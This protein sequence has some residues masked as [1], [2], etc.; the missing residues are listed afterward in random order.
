[1]NVQENYNFYNKQREENNHKRYIPYTIDSTM[2]FLNDY[3]EQE[4]I[5]MFLEFNEM[6]KVA[7]NKSFLKLDELNERRFTT[8][9]RLF[10]NSLAE[11]MKTSAKNGNW[12]GEKIAIFI[13]ENSFSN[14][15]EMKFET[16]KH[17]LWNLEKANKL[18]R[19]YYKMKTSWQ[20]IVLIDRFNNYSENTIKL[21]DLFRITGTYASDI[22]V[23]IP[24]YNVN[25]V[26]R[27]DPSCFKVM[28]KGKNSE[29]KCIN[30]YCK[31]EKL[32]K[33]SRK[34]NYKS[35]NTLVKEYNEVLN[36]TKKTDGTKYEE[37]L[38]RLNK[39]INEKIKERNS[40][41][42]NEN[43]KYYFK[44]HKII[45]GL[46][47]K[48]IELKHEEN[49]KKISHDL[50][51]DTELFKGALVMPIMKKLVDTI[52]YEDFLKLDVI[53]KKV[54]RA[55]DKYTE[56]YTQRIADNN[57]Y[58]GKGRFYWY[59]TKKEN[60]TWDYFKNNKMGKKYYKMFYKWFSEIK[61][62][63]MI[64]YFEW[65]FKNYMYWPRPIPFTHL[66]SDKNFIWW[67]KNSDFE[68]DGSDG[69]VAP[70]VTAKE[71]EPP[72]EEKI[73]D[74]LGKW[75]HD[76]ELLTEKT[77]LLIENRELFKYT[78]EC[79][80]IITALNVTLQV[81][82]NYMEWQKADPEKYVFYCLMLE[83]YYFETFKSRAFVDA[84]IEELNLG[85]DFLKWNCNGNL[86]YRIL[87][88]EVIDV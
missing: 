88:G 65:I 21:L 49:K 36:L 72:K 18:I 25:Y 80:R 45:R 6:L 41:I 39:L 75:N 3:S 56:L 62:N 60:F 67:G 34:S 13:N 58:N 30:S 57:E 24:K 37:E 44:N 19:I 69:D 54:L 28:V 84:K 10:A 83:A 63:A 26:L 15:G 46:E 78:K 8:G 38:Q 9:C 27:K 73:L 43:R 42:K 66:F 35:L 32:Y 50:S 61:Y 59:W 5:K 17:H 74:E 52:P 71:Y 82:K 31:I 14:Y 85:R 11:L 2:P 4:I 64:E 76:E 1:M 68:D 53:D 40:K 23:K 7:G 29:I 77:K 48:L 87:S 12:M 16:I 33:A 47:V 79:N 22:E 51:T 86:R 81:N 55:I 70:R 20:M